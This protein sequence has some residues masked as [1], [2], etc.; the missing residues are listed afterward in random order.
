LILLRRFFSIEESETKLSSLALELGADVPFFLS[1]QKSAIGKGLGE[2][3]Q[4]VDGIPEDRF[5]LIAWPGFQISTAKAYQEVDNSLTYASGNANLW[6]RSIDE[7]LRTD[8]GHFHND[9][10]TIAFSSH[11]VLLHTRNTLLQAGAETAGLSGSGSSLFAIFNGEAAA[12][13]AA[14]TLRAPWQS[15]LCRPC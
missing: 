8:D 3:L 13:N 1:D 9:F 11:P 15:F 14:S 12:R 7:N 4:P 5:I 6:V 2:Q 10:E